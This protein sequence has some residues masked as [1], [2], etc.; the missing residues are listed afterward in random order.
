MSTWTEEN[1]RWEKLPTDLEVINTNLAGLTIWLGQV[2][3]N[4]FTSDAFIHHRG[5]LRLRRDASFNM[6]NW[7]IPSKKTVQLLPLF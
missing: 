6:P 3:A 1:Q 2:E 7:R 4:S 5:D